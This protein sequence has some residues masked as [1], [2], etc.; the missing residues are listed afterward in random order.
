MSSRRGQK[1]AARKARL[2]NERA[3][4]E[5]R[6]RRRQ[7]LSLAGGFGVVIVIA[8]ALLLLAQGHSPT[9][10]SPQPKAGARLPPYRTHD[11]TAAARM[12]GARQISPDYSFGIGD[13]TSGKVT[14]PTNPPTNGPHFFTPAL[15]GSYVG[16]SSP[17]TEQ[18][19]HSLEHERVVIQYRPGL[20]ASTLRELEALYAESPQHVLLVENKT[21]MPCD[22]AAT[23]WAHGVLCPHLTQASIDALR[24]FRDKYR[25][26]GPER[27]P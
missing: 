22:V 19:V 17:R 9:N 4:A 1:E 18:V 26:Q 5:R 23:A 10:S 7:R 11:L 2:A 25:D 15:D 3:D 12:A 13:H 20:Q 21:S 8:G 6:A 27:I 16:K 24:A 14:Y